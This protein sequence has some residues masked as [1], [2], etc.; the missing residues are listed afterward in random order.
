MRR[1]P[2]SK[3]VTVKPRCRLKIKKSAAVSPTVVDII[4]INQNVKVTSGTLLSKLTVL[5]FIK[6]LLVLVTCAFVLSENVL[7]YS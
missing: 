2:I 3:E 5:V 7:N 4:L 1:T 6:Y